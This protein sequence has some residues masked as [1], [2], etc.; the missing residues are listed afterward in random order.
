MASLKSY[1]AWAQEHFD[2]IQPEAHVFADYGQIVEMLK[3]GVIYGFA[4]DKAATSR[5]EWQRP[6]KEK[7]WQ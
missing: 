3:D 2:R 4:S 7:E 5:R 6:A 1:R